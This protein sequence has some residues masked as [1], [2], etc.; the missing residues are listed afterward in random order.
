MREKLA[1]VSVKSN[2][3]RHLLGDRPSNAWNVSKTTEKDQIKHTTNRI[4]FV[5]TNEPRESITHT[6][7]CEV[8]RRGFRNPAESQNANQALLTEGV[9]NRDA[10]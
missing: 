4:K 9:G 3:L 5:P 6:S 8:V 7:L 1:K 10:D 2:F